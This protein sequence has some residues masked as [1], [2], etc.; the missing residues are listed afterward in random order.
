MNP[1]YFLNGLLNQAAAEE[2]PHEVLF[3]AAASQS[4]TVDDEDV[5]LKTGTFAIGFIGLGDGSP[6]HLSRRP[7]TLTPVTFTIPRNVGELRGH[8]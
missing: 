7:A 6:W 3:V 2:G 1:L 5:L 8:P 4:R